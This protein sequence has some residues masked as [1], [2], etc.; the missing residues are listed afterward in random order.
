MNDSERLARA[1]AAR[2][3][4]WALKRLSDQDLNFEIEDGTSSL[5]WCALRLR[6]PRHSEEKEAGWM[7]HIIKVY[8]HDLALA[9]RERSRREGYNR[10]DSLEM[11]LR[12]MFPPGPSPENQ[13]A[14]RAARNQA[15]IASSLVDSL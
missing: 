13:R 12:R 4:S 6:E 7:D 1:S 5:A 11:E 8:A 2:N 15:K 3:H 10:H 9:I 14:R